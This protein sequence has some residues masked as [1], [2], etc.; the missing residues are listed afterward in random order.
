MS[1]LKSFESVYFWSYVLYNLRLLRKNTW[2]P[3]LELERMQIKK[4]RA[5]LKYAY[6]STAF[7]HQRFDAAKIKPGDIKSAED[8]RKIPILTKLEV[9]K[10]FNSLIA[11]GIDIERCTKVETSGSTGIP[12]TIISE[13]RASYILGAN[14]LRHYIENGGKLFR[15]KYVFLTTRTLPSKRTRLG[16]FL[17]HLGIFRRVTMCTRD[18]IEDLVNE[19]INFRPDVILGYPSFLLLLVRELEKRGGVIHPRLVFG[20]GEL[21]DDRSR[22]L[23][24]SAFRVKMLDTYGCMEAGDIAWECPEHAGYHINMDLVVTEFVKDGEHVAAG[25]RGDII[26]TPLWNY[27]MPLIRYKVNDIGTPSNKCCP[28]GRGLPLMKVLEGRFEDFII[29]PSGRI[30]YPFNIFP[31]F[32]ENIEGIAE[33]RIIQE[34]K[35]NF[36]L[37]LVLK[38]GYNE[39]AIAQLR[40]RFIEE[41]REDVTINIEVL[42]AIPR[43][44]KLRRVVSKCMPREQFFSF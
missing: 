43:N 25:E 28:C 35:D 10:N 44:G 1:Y 39:N 17:N 4:L 9:Q 8:M 36:I 24:D 29:L 34:R 33:Y 19:L 42:D 23:I 41:F 14:R 22:K 18:P 30:I 26:L 7:Y 27:A 15:D 3:S 11:R 32:F 16:S 40:N 13:K 20:E 6:E 31:F 5:I 2:L 12:L 21:L 38:E 37:Q